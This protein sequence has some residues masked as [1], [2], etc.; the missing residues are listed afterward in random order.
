MS[1]KKYFGFDEKLNDALVEARSE[2][3]TP[4]EDKIL[5]LERKL[6]TAKLTHAEIAELQKELKRLKSS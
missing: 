3:V 6:E 5:Q 4:K 1:L 2:K